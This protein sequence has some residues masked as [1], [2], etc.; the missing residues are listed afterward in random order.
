MSARS[1]ADDLSALAPIAAERGGWPDHTVAV[2]N[3][4]H[5]VAA[6][7]QV[8]NGSDAE[9]ALLELLSRMRKEAE[10]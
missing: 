9:G 6:R 1:P 8:P 3:E 4:H 10:T 7:S 2:V 5:V